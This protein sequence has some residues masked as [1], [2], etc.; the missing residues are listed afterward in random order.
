MSD[1]PV[2]AKCGHSEDDLDDMGICRVEG[3][4]CV[5]FQPQYEEV[6]DDD[7]DGFELDDEEDDG[8]EELDFDEE[9]RA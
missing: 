9:E 4:R 2:C 7:E 1:D 3:C 8:L 6:V 5:S